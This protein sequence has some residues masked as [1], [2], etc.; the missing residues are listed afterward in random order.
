[1][2]KM[3]LFMAA[4]SAIGTLVAGIGGFIAASLSELT[5]SVNALN[6]KVAVVIE[7]TADH[8][9]RITRLETSKAS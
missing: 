2:D 5:K 7:Q 4:V 3:T 8:D 6:I 9:K 1:M